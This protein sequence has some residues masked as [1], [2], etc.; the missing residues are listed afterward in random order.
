[1]TKNETCNRTFGPNR[2]AWSLWDDLVHFDLGESGATPQIWRDREALY[3]E[4]ASS[5][6]FLRHDVS[7]DCFRLQ[8]EVAIPGHAGFIGLVFGAR[9]SSNFELAY[10][11]PEEIQYD[12][13]MNG[14][15][16]W[17]VYNGPSYQKPLPNTTGVWRTLAVEVQPSGAAVY[18]DDDPE[19]QLVVSNLQHGGAAGQ[20]G[21]WNFLPCYIRNL[22]V[23]EIQPS[24]IVRTNREFHRLLSETFV[25]EW[26]VS[27]P[28]HKNGHS[29]VLP[30]RTKAYV[31][32]N[33]TLN[34]NRMYSAEQGATVQAFSAFSISEE[35][36]T[37]VTFGFSDQLRLWV[38]EEEV[39]EGKWGWSPPAGDG[40]IRPDFAGVPIRWRAGLNTIR[41]EITNHEGFGWGLSLRTGLSGVQFSE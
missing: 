1:M 38:N 13:V 33:G 37:L 32:E 34:I 18:L 39:Y 21:F 4:K 41:A 9:D 20:I 15:M 26:M 27:E 24:P 10:L 11:A 25:M 12:P 36:E 14:S 22:S 8:A 16:T 30:G 3:L 35:K 17:Q 7:F 28:Y 2:L 6:V 40:R 5:A 31:E 23:T 19:P 29:V